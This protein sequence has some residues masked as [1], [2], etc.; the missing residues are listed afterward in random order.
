MVDAP[1]Y[2]FAKGNPREVESWNKLM[3]S[4]IN[5]SPYLHR[6]LALIDAEHGFKKMDKILFD[7]L[8]KKMKPYIIVLTKCDKV[9]PDRIE[10]LYEEI[11]KEFGKNALSSPMIHATSARYWL[12]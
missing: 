4:Y 3:S 1:G 10:R 12:S 8:E 7:L 5:G 11:K 2:G 9:K 6:V